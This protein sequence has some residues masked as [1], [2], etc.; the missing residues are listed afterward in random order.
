MQEPAVENE[1]LKILSLALL[2]ELFW[3]LQEEPQNAKMLLI[4]QVSYFDNSP[5]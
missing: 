5:N 2:L 1:D 4:R 3:S